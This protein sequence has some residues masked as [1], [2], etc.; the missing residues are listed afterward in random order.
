MQPQAA[1]SLPQ[2]A[3]LVASATAR[4]GQVWQVVALGL[5]GGASLACQRRQ[6]GGRTQACRWGR[7]T[8]R[9]RSLYMSAT[10]SDSTAPTPSSAASSS[11]YISK[12]SS[13]INHR[14]CTASIICH[15]SRYSLLTCLIAHH[16]ELPHRR[17][18]AARLRPGRNPQDEA[19]EDLPGGAAGTFAF[20]A[21]AVEC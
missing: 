16:E 9:S 14:C 20:T 3:I 7:S 18:G 21:F 17:R 5:P 12:Q 15:S 11:F 19:A 1:Q 10:T 13:F 6:P 4:V 8:R 2:A